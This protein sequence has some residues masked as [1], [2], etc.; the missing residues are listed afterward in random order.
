MDNPIATAEAFAPATIANLGVGFDIVG[1]ALR[2]LGDT[3]RAEW[4]DE[5]GVTIAIEGDG[6]KLPRE[7]AKNTAGVSALSV[8]RVLGET[9][10]VKL[11]IHKGLP[12]ASGLGSSAASA[13]GGAVVVNALLGSPLSKGELLPACLDGEELASGRHAD[14]VAPCL[15]GGITLVCGIHASQIVQ[16][17]IPDHLYFALVTPAVE[18]PTKLAREALPPTVS[19]RTMVSQTAGAARLIDSIHRGDLE[20][21]AAAMESDCVIEPA[22]QSLMPLL[23]EIRSA[24]KAAGALGW[25]ISGAGPTLCA[26]CAGESVAQRVAVAMHA[27]YALSGIPCQSRWTQIAA[28]GARTL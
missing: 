17:P 24:A 22:R 10:G 19:L 23:T 3:I 6:G 21:M 13:V 9:R 5:P 25:V 12:P 14:N 27:V 18:V 26:V 2:D 15:F 11:T 20:S 7:A 8:L 1:A 4:C 28:D 16:L